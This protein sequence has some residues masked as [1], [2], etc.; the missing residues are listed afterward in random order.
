MSD[1]SLRLT[2]AGQVL[3]AK[4]Q[5]GKGTIPLEITRIVTASGRSDDPL[6]LLAVVDERQQFLVTSRLQVGVRA[7]IGAFM[8]N[9][10]NPDPD[11]FVSPLEEGYPL[12]QIGFYAMDPDDGEILYRISQF[13]NPNWVPAFTERG[14]EYIPKFYFSTGN[15]SEVIIQIDPSGLATVEMLTQHIEQSIHSEDGSHGIRYFNG[16]LQVNDGVSW[17]SITT[18]GDLAVH[19]TDPNAHADKFANLQKQLNEITAF[20]HDRFPDAIGA[21]LGADA[22]L[23][24]D[25]TFMTG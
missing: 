18:S 14:W 3:N 23:G 2:E 16:V 8:S 25:D 1:I 4:I 17:V 9:Y 5:Q 11:N 19:N 15:A 20:L 21:Y 7:I 22:F 24:A 13:D 10:G 6:G 12:S